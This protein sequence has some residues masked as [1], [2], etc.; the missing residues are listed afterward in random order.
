MDYD[1]PSL[2]K[3]PKAIQLYIDAK[4]AN[5]NGKPQRTSSCNALKVLSFGVPQAVNMGALL[6]RNNR[7]LGQLYHNY[8]KQPPQ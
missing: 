4:P 6:I 5:L 1:T 7:V 2:V 8:D 3:E